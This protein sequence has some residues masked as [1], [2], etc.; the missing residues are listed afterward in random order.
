MPEKKT[1]LQLLGLATLV[2]A[3]IAVVIWFFQHN[4]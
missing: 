1:L 4:D 3:A 2:G